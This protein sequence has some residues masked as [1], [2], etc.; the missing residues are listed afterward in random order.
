M[1]P[2]YPV[3][4][5][6]AT[7]KWE[8]RAGPKEDTQPNHVPVDHMRS[9]DAVVVGSGPN[10][11]AGA[12][13]LARSGLVVDVIEGAASPGGGC[14]TEELTLAG[15]RHDVCSAAHPLL[16]SSSFLTGPLDRGGIKLLTPEV[17]FA[18]PLDGGRA[19]IVRGDV[20]ETA[21]S[22]GRDAASY[23]RLFSPLVRNSDRIMSAVLSPIRS[24]PDH[25]LAVGR[26]ALEGV[27]PAKLLAR[28]F[29]TVEARAL[30][31]GASAHAMLPLTAPLSGAF[32][33][34]LTMLAHTVGWP[35]VEGG[36]ARIADALL[37]ELESL[38]GMVQ[39]GRWVESLADIP[40]ARVVLL[41]VS[42]RQLLALGPGCFSKK[43]RRSLQRFE[44]GPGVCKV[45]WAL[46][47]AVPW[48]APGCLD[49]GTLH[50][51]GTFEEIAA[52]EA[53]VAE[54]RHP[55][56]PYCLVVQPSVV[57]PS[58]APGDCQTLWGYCHVPRGSD[59]D[60]TGPIESQ[61]ERYAPG[62][63]DLIIGRATMTSVQMAEHNPN[64]I[65]GHINGGAATLRQTILG[66]MKKWNPYATGISGVYLCSA[67]TP[68]GG[69]VHGMCGVGAARSALA[70]IGT[71]PTLKEAPN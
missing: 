51:G 52:S 47:G 32:G 46:S 18:H 71:S 25:P 53:D 50:I 45:D 48:S 36:S 58:R 37:A 5:R 17:A 27:L 21:L 8:P 39:T 10:G 63:R 1:G 15:F 6:A 11:L 20:E 2:F 31:A 67:S 3:G 30:L 49:A 14:R 60:M 42:P 62:F 38:G 55:D 70:D 61:I 54:G 26:F 57:D 29:D 44:Y 65:G 9:P 41:D 4:R 69:G 43:T 59:V 28:R 40:R 33:L 35:V 24:V 56:K 13:T 12:L 16:A 22:L 19:A 23:K 68:P 66:P 64:Y 34:L 7:I